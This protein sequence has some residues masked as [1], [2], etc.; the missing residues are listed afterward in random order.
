M[1]Y[2]LVVN[3]QLT[4]NGMREASKLR[5]LFKNGR[6]VLTGNESKIIVPKLLPLRQRNRLLIGYDSVL[7][8]SIIIVPKT[9]LL[10]HTK[11]SGRSIFL[12]DFT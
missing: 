4:K 8:K 6:L 3:H 5:E 2:K 1:V 9:K 7:K 12:I 10:N 11:T